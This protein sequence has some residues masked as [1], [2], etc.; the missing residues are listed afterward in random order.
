MPDRYLALKRIPKRKWEVET[1]TEEREHVWGLKTQH[2]ISFLR[3]LVYHCLVLSGSFGFWAW[4]L[5]KHPDDVQSAAV[6]FHNGPYASLFV[7]ERFW[8]HK[9]LPQARVA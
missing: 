8:Y 7:L 5:V 3:V 6:P 1:K 4:W 9:E 2:V